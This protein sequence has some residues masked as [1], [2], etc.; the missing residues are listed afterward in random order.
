MAAETITARP[1]EQGNS[2][3]SF[4]KRWLQPQSQDREVAFR[5]RSIRIAIA[6]VIIIGLLSF[7]FTIF[8]FHNAWRLISFPTLHVEMLAG[9]FAAAYLVSRARVNESANVLIFTS[10]IGAS[11]YIILSAQEASYAQLISGIPVFMFVILLSALVMQRNTIIPIG[12][13]GLIFYVITLLSTQQTLNNLPAF[14]LSQAYLPA[15]FLFPTEAVIL[16]RLRVEFDARLN[17]MRESIRQ[18]ELAQQQAEEARQQ[19]E[20][21]RVRAEEADKAKSQFLAN[22]SHE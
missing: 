6:V 2:L 20:K 7:V 16:L 18:A 3:R 4:P 8:V 19:A 9:S 14:D 12:F 17:A 22:M 10:L 11:G 1:P 5:E 21:E 15:F 13:A